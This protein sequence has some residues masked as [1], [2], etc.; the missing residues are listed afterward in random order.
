MVLVYL[1]VI[2]LIGIVLI[3]IISI[4]KFRKEKTALKKLVK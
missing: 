3:A 4:I 1:M 2:I